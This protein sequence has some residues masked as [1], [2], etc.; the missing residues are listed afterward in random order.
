LLKYLQETHK[1]ALLS[2]KSFGTYSLGDFMVLDAETRRNL[3]RPKLCGMPKAKDPCCGCWT[4]PNPDG[5]AHAAPMGQQTLL[6]LAAITA[7][8]IWSRRF[9]DGVLR[10]EIVYLLHELHDME[11][12][13]NRACS[14]SIRPRSWSPARGFAAAAQTARAPAA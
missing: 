10:N 13:V 3:E 7:G 4:R 9:T 2:L 12:L 5:E 8:W 1:D 14:N 11:R 6:N